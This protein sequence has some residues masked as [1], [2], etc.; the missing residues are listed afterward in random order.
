MD[1]QL[2]GQ[3]L[4][5]CCDALDICHTRTPPATSSLGLVGWVPSLQL[6]EEGK[7]RPESLEDSRGQSQPQHP[8][9]DAFLSKQIGLSSKFQQALQ[10]VFF[11]SLEGESLIY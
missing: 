9:L 11:V 8:S 6:A 4:S 5:D 3:H 10:N 2:E 1:G 7:R